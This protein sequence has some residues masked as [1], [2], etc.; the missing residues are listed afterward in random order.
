MK[1]NAGVVL[2]AGQSLYISTG[3]DAVK[4]TKNTTQ[5]VQ[6]LKSNTGKS[7]TY[8]SFAQYSLPITDLK[9]VLYTPLILM[10]WSCFCTTDLL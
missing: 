6:E 3:D 1:A 2:K 7:D 8:C 4:L 5:N 9:G 10:Y